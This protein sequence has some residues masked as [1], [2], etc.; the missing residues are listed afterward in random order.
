MHSIIK[1]SVSQLSAQPARHFSLKIGSLA[2]VFWCLATTSCAPGLGTQLALDPDVLINTDEELTEP[3]AFTIE[4]Q[5]AERCTGSVA[6]QSVEDA[7][8]SP[9][10][11]T[12]VGRP[13]LSAE[14]IGQVTQNMLTSILGSRGYE[15]SSS[16]DV[17]LTAKV[18]TLH[19]SINSSF[20]TS[21]VAASAAVEIELVNSNLERLYGGAF[22]GQARR[23]EAFLSEEDVSETISL[24]LAQALDKSAKSADFCR[25]LAGAGLP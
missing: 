17:A 13:V 3:A 15:V 12:I 20:P 24:A 14:P 19:G 10:I 22:K 1:L 4:S 6:I 7:R 25:V 8:T 23:T 11:A 21:S 5:D 2:L 18:T 9:P 16:S